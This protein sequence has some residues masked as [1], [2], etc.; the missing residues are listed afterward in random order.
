MTKEL[1]RAINVIRDCTRPHLDSIRLL[2]Q[3]NP[4]QDNPV[5]KVHGIINEIEDELPK[6]RARARSHAGPRGDPLRRSIYIAMLKVWKELTGHLPARNNTTFHD[7]A[8]AA[9]Q[10]IHPNATDNYILGRGRQKTD[11]LRSVIEIE[12][13][14]MA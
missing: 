11:R 2:L 10:S 6:L 9:F 3:I 12:L 5:V 4:R 7:F 8:H 14:G 1:E 13:Q